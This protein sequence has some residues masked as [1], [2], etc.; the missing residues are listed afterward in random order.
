MICLNLKSD[1][2]QARQTKHVTSAALMLRDKTLQQ[3]QRPTQPV[4][5]RLHCKKTNLL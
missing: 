4:C 5:K 2:Y 1:N 3:Q